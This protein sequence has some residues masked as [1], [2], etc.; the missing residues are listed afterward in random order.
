MSD[1][2]VIIP[3]FNLADLTRQCLETV[4]QSGAREVIVV[5]D[6][7]TDETARM[8][9]DYDPRVRVVTHAENQGFARSC[10]DGAAAATSEFLVFLNN[11]TVPQPG[12]LA[13]LESYARAHPRAAVVGCKLLFP[14]HTVQHAGAVICQ[15]GYP[16]HIYRGFPADHP[17][18]SVSRRFRIVTAACMLVRRAIFEE[19]A[20][21]DAAFRNGFEDVDLCLR[22]GERGHEVHYC[23]EAVVYHYESLSPGRSKHDRAN[24][25]LYRARWKS[26]IAPDDLDYYVQDGLLKVSYEGRYPIGLEIS[27]QLAVIEGEARRADAERL[28]REQGRRISDLQRENTR[29]RVELGPRSGESPELAYQRMRESA[30]ALVAAKTERG[31][32]VLVVS[33]GDGLLL[34]FP[35][36]TGWHFPRTDAGAY[37]GHH[38]EDSAAALAHLAEL[39]KLGAA[40]FLIPSTSLW[41]LEY[42]AEFGRHLTKHAVRLDAP[43]D[44]A[45]LFRLITP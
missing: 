30:R 43:D 40:Y 20:G 29:L 45:A 3:V 44:G 2:S 26:R 27:P 19:V 15:D 17:A 12:W 37:A 14:D 31:A 13:T 10:N 36:R 28:L 11:D 33:N 41:W 6:A 24:V 5:D 34:D 35:D 38:P 9:A 25:D 8:L 39:R 42:Y 21:F 4:L 16:R 22:L 23:A 7:S 32:I 18:V 1:A